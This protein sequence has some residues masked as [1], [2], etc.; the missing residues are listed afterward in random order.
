MDH[1]KRQVDDFL[2]DTV[3]EVLVVP[4]AQIDPGKVLESSLKKRLFGDRRVR[5]L[6]SETDPV[7]AIRSA[8]AITVFGGNTFL[9]LF[10]L[11]AR[12][13]LD[14]IRERVRSGM[15]YVGMSAGINITAPTIMT[16]N[17]MPIIQPPSFK[18]LGLVPFQINPHYFSGKVLFRSPK[19]EISEYAGE[20]RDDRLTEFHAL[21]DTPI[22]GLPE[23]TFLRIEGGAATYLAL[24]SGAHARVFRKGKPTQEVQDRGDLSRLLDLAKA[25]A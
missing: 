2:G 13:L 14:P 16:T 5:S 3:Q 1:L 18:A 9:L 25:G 12:E 23:A 15:P 8:E 21:H 22:L 4:F 20:T 6:A 7:A 17:D 24:D 11:Y 10:E 19:G